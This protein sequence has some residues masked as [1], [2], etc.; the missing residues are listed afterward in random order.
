MLF[1]ERVFVIVGIVCVSAERTRVLAV[2][3]KTIA[4]LQAAL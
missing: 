3:W 4:Q 1:T 2:D